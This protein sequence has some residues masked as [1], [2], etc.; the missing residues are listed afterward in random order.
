MRA[1]G[2]FLV[3]IASACTVG[4]AGGGGGGDD[5]GGDDT[6][7]PDAATTTN[8]CPLPETTAD[9]GA[10]T[11]L[12]AQRC[13]V[14]GSMGTRQWYRLSASLPGSALRGRVLAFPSE[15]V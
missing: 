7:A 8:L 10:L 5:T 14:S 12:K 3:L 1:L 6:M 15:R 11:A 13:N 9:T 4:S 2:L